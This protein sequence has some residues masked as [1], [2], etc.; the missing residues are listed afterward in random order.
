M[1]YYQELRNDDWKFPWARQH[2]GP[3]VSGQ[4]LSLPYV[5][6]DILEY[7]TVCAYIGALGHLATE[8]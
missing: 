8:I 3:W 2:G 4:Q 5:D 6:A 1:P 7:Q